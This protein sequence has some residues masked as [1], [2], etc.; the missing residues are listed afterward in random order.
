MAGDLIGRTVRTTV[1]RD[2]RTFDVE[3]VPV[4]LAV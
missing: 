2:G 4:E 3:L 1:F